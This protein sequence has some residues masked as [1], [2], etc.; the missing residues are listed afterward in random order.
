L[1]AS[2]TTLAAIA[3]PVPTT[4]LLSIDELLETVCPFFSQFIVP[5]FSLCLFIPP[6]VC[7][8]QVVNDVSSQ[9][10]GQCLVSMAGDIPFQEMT[11]HCEAFSMGKHHKMSLLMSFKQNKQAAMVVVPDN[12]VSHAEAAHTSDK[13]VHGP[14]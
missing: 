1:E 14:A 12:Q 9:T 8:L 7:T 2:A 3:I 10:G 5:A 13:Q 11:S 6:S 4:N